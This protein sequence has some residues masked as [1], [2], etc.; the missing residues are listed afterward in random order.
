MNLFNGNYEAKTRKINLLNGR[1]VFS[2]C[3]V[4]V[5]CKIKQKKGNVYNKINYDLI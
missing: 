2:K 1:E 3:Y 5:K 4:S